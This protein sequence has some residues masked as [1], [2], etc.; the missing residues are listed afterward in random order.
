MG[1]TLLERQQDHPQQVVV[2]RGGRRVIAMDSSRFVDA[3]N[4]NRDVVTPASYIGV[5]PARLMADH[6]PRPVI[7]HDACV[8]KDGVGVAGLW[9]LKAIGIPTACAD[10][11]FFTPQIPCPSHLCEDWGYRQGSGRARWGIPAHLVG[12]PLPEIDAGPRLPA[13]RSGKLNSVS[14]MWTRRNPMT[15]IR[16]LLG[17]AR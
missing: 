16:A 12:E 11:N 10:G 6:R 2:E 17:R 5:L 9:R 8:V 14:P 13:R 4:T 3:R 1:K 7:G 15:C